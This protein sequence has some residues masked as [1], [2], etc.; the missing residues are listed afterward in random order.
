VL[1]LALIEGGPIRRVQLDALTA[2][3]ELKT[4]VEHTMQGRGER[5]GS[6]VDRTKEWECWRIRRDYALMVGIN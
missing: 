6:M 4:S 2:C 1:L 5:C 3:F